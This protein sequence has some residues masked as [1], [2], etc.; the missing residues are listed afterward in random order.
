MSKTVTSEE[1]NRNASAVMPAAESEPVLIT[2]H[3][4]SAFVLLRLSGTAA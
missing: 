3:G 1:L 4:Q 2:D